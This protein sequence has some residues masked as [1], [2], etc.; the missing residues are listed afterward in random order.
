MSLNIRVEWEN[1]P[2][3][4]DVVDARLWGR[5]EIHAGGPGADEVVLTEALLAESGSVRRGVYGSCYPLARWIV[6]S[7]WA[8]L[9]EAQRTPEARAGR[10]LARIEPL[11]GWVQRHCLLAA[12]EGFSLPDV[13]LA[14]DGDELT[15]L[16]FADPGTTP[17]GGRPVRFLTSCHLRLDRR[18]VERALHTFMDSV[19]ERLRD[20]DHPDVRRLSADWSAITRADPHEAALCR[21]AARMGLDPYDPEEFPDE[22]ASRVEEGLRALNAGLQGDLLDAVTTRKDFETSLHWLNAND[23]NMLTAHH[24]LSQQAVPPPS[25][26]AHATGYDRARRLRREL[27][28]ATADENVVGSVG[29]RLGFDFGRRR[30]PSTTPPDPIESLV[31]SGDGQVP[32]LIGPELGFE[33]TSFRW[34]RALYLWRCGHLERGARLLTTGHERL[35]REGRAFAAELLAPAAALRKR[36]SHGM[37]GEEKLLSLASDFRV[38]PMVIKHQLENHGIA[39]VV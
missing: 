20:V 33:G 26:T 12:R 7:Y 31:V 13:T 19:F 5:L 4:V 2:G 25:A 3:V 36:V 15:L 16:A 38:S 8:L 37:V 32:V 11:R 18:Q 34:A 14:R 39:L 17:A 35:Q 28:L 10:D 30:A 23:L 9:W 29:S 27:G 21:W 24:P 22:F 6:D 1:A